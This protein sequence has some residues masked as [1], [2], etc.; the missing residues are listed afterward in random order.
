MGKAE[1]MGKALNVPGF[2]EALFSFATRC[3]ANTD[4]EKIVDDV[5]YGSENAEVVSGDNLNVADDIPP[6]PPPSVGSFNRGSCL[7]TTYDDPF[8]VGYTNF[9]Q[10]HNFWAK[11]GVLQQQDGVKE[12]QICQAN[13]SKVLFMIDF[14]IVWLTFSS[15]S[16]LHPVVD[17]GLNLHASCYKVLVCGRVGSKFS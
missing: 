13:F 12:D 15:K 3:F 4:K 7:Q 10:S 9:C 2:Y 16:N 1:F 11:F 17:G 14:F 5:E 6:P 8:S